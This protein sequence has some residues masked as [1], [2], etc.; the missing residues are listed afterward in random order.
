MVVVYCGVMQSPSK[1][2]YNGFGAAMSQLFDEYIEIPIQSANVDLRALNHVD[3]CF[4]Q[5]H[6]YGIEPETLQHLKNIG[7][8]TIN[9]VGD[10]RNNT[11]PYC[12]E[13]AQHVNLSCFSNMKDVRFMREMGYKSEFLQIG[14]DNAIYYPD[15]EVTK[16]IDIVF[17][18]NR[19]GHFPLSGMR[20]ELVKELKK[21]Y[22]DMFKAY[23]INQPDGNFMGDQKGE[24]DIYRRAKI[25]INLSHYDYERYSSDRLFRML[26]SGVCV[27]SHN[28]NGIEQDFVKG[29][30]I[31]W[32][33]DF[34]ELKMQI[35]YYLNKFNR[36][37]LEWMGL[38]L[39]LREFTFTRMAQNILQLY[40]EHKQN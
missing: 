38:D 8:F 3:I 5:I 2:Q 33:N 6:D 10:A 17:L 12:F 23:G 32:W 37:N 29:K 9:W 30:E 14:A 26:L 39:G 22:G 35:E 28:Y 19:Y 18:A 25:G 15:I 21:T 13:Y 40:N 27:L 4:M 24:A 16:D 31:D 20:D 1:S 7:C 11:P 34:D 36:H